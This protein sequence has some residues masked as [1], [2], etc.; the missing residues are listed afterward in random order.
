MDNPA[1]ILA[2]AAGLAAM[3]NGPYTGGG[4]QYERAP[5]DPNPQRSV[6]AAEFKHKKKRRKMARASKKN[7]RKKH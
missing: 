1:R 2:A 7:N 4:E 3:A 5:Y 6:G